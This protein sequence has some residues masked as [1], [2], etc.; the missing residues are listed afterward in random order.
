MENDLFSKLFLR[1]VQSPTSWEEKI[2]ELVFA[3][4]TQLKDVFAEKDAGILLDKKLYMIQQCDLALMKSGGIL[5][6]TSK[7][8]ASR[9]KEVILPLSSALLKP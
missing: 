5:G 7:H 3:G 8:V 6:C 1:A 4:A 2:H 9:L